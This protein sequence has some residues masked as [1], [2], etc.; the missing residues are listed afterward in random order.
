MIRLGYRQ[1]LAATYLLV[2]AVSLLLISAYLSGA[3]Q[4]HF[5]SG[6]DG[7]LS[8][9]ATLAAEVIRGELDRAGDVDTLAQE[10]G[11]K[12]GLRVTVISLDG[13]VI[14]DSESDFRS[15][16]NHGDRPEIIEAHSVGVGQQLGTAPA[17]VLS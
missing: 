15:M 11:R 1:R 9:Y 14:G 8:T 6:L 10:L 16:E 4:R 12:T 13:S 3:I 2:A 5:V 17:S 7:E